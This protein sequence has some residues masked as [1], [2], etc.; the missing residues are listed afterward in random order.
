M[1]SEMYCQLRRI[2]RI[3]VPREDQRQRVRGLNHGM[4]RTLEE[5]NL[6]IV[7]AAILM[8]KPWCEL[9][10]RQP[11]LPVGARSQFT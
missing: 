9:I 2:G 7:R 4:A 8:S 3:A 6:A 11:N 1:S 10:A 5:G